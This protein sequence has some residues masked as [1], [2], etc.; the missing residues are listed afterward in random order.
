MIFSNF[1][2]LIAFFTFSKLLGNYCEL[3]DLFFKFLEFYFWNF[4]VFLNDWEICDL[5]NIWISLQNYVVFKS[6]LMIWCFQNI[7]VFITKFCHFYKSLIILSYFQNFWVFIA[8]IFHFVKIIEDVI[9]SNY[10]IF[11]AE[12][13]LLYEIF[14][15][16][17]IFL[18]LKFLNFYKSFRTVLNFCFY[19]W[20]VSLFEIFENVVIVVRP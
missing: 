6:L 20:N 4:S 8:E 12:F 10:C 15:N 7:W 1:G 5:L 19:S 16:F 17:M 13:S 11:I 3:C 14:E 18:L 2:F 9:F